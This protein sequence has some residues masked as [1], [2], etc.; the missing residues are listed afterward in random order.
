MLEFGILRLVNLL[1]ECSCIA[2]LTS[3]VIVI[4][5]FVFHLVFCMLLINRSY[6]SCLCVM[7][8]LGNL[9]WQYVNSMNCIL[10]VG[11]G[12]KG[13]GD[14]LGACSKFSV[15]GRSWARHWQF[16]CGHVY[17]ISHSTRLR[18]I[19]RQH[20]IIYGLLLVWIGKNNHI[21]I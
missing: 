4:T 12:V 3:A 19:Y 1:M 2:P 18:L 15:Y 20:T 17:F 11:V 7:A 16:V 8:C 5:G 6:L 21:R 10:C 14:W 9:S 13:V